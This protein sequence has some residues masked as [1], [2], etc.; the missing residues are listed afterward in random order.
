MPRPSAP[1]RSFDRS[2]RRV[3]R[4]ALS[5]ASTESLRVVADGLGLRS[6]SRK[7]KSKLIAELTQLGAVTTYS[8]LE[9]LPDSDLRAACRKVIGSDGGKTKNERIMTLLGSAASPRGLK[10]WLKAIYTDTAID[11]ASAEIDW[12]TTYLETAR[13]DGTLP[14]ALHSDDSDPVLNSARLICELAAFA[15]PLVLREQRYINQSRGGRYLLTIASSP[16]RWHL[17]VATV[18]DPWD[19]GFEYLFMAAQQHVNFDIVR[20]DGKDLDNS[21]VVAF[22]EAINS[23]LLEEYGDDE[24]VGSLTRS[25]TGCYVVLVA[26]WMFRASGGRRRKY[27]GIIWDNPATKLLKGLGARLRERET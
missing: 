13:L 8:I 4:A 12:I 19:F 18:Y 11:P 1:S 22:G 27:D 21:E 23:D 17:G 7:T 10:E 3:R 5:F 20:V 16:A 24:V 9:G 2:F 26:P 6:S 25:N 14:K 15:G